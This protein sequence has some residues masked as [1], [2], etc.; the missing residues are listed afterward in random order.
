MPSKV[1]S[2]RITTIPHLHIFILI[3][4]ALAMDS[5]NCKAIY[6]FLNSSIERAKS[7]DKPSHTVSRSNT[8]GDSIPYS[9]KVKYYWRKYPIQCQGQI[10]LEKVSHTVSRSN[11]IGE[12][13]PSVSRSNTIGE[14]HNKCKY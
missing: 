7:C 10:L 1:F 4:L 2:F 6:I 13:I 5:S 12:S 9:V 14:M 11:T 8:I 3:F